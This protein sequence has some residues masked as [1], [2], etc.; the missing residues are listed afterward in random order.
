MLFCFTDQIER[1]CY[2]N[3]TKSV[4]SL[5]EP[6]QGINALFN[7]SSGY[8]VSEV[9][10]LYILFWSLSS[11]LD[12]VFERDD[13]KQ[14]ETNYLI[15]KKESYWF[16]ELVCD[17]SQNLWLKERIVLPFKLLWFRSLNSNRI[18]SLRWVLSQSLFLKPLKSIKSDSSK[19]Q[20]ELLLV[21]W[22]GMEFH[23]N[24]VIMWLVVSL[25]VSTFPKYVC[26]YF[27]ISRILLE[28]ECERWW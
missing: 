24:W 15:F 28:C 20:M 26:F 27:L 21:R 3:I 23:F 22:L 18:K 11:H 2:S 8:L 19:I 9:F 13:E 5:A 7:F 17:F 6:C 10:F 1:V 12:S 25:L 16:L 14:Q 4:T